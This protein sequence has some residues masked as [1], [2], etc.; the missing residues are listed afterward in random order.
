MSLSDYDDQKAAVARIQR[1]LDEQLDTIR[2]TRSYSDAGR[3]AE[4]AKAVLAARAQVEKLRSEFVAERETRRDNLH[5]IIFG[6]PSGASA[7][8]LIANRDA[9]DRAAQISTPEDAKAMLHRANQTNDESLAR[10]VA[11]VLFIEGGQRWLRTTQT[12]WASAEPSTCSPTPTPARAPR[13]ADATVFRIRN[14]AELG[15]GLES[16]STLNNLVKDAVG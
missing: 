10:A 6:S 13:L 15:L 3:K 4:M 1:R 2:N 11:R 5:R 8:E 16:E 9:Q 12:R 14:P 7:S